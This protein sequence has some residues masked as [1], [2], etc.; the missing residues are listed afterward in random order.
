MRVLPKMWTQERF[1]YAGVSFAMP[2]RA[3]IPKPLQKPHPPL[4]VTV[5]SPGTELDAD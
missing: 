3:I 5:T 4:W 1:A 2:E